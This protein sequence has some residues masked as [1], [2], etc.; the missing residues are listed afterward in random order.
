[1]AHKNQCQNCIITWIGKNQ[2]VFF[3]FQH[4]TTI[5]IKLYIPND[6]YSSEI[7]TSHTLAAIGIKWSLIFPTPNFFAPLSIIDSHSL[8]LLQTSPSKLHALQN[9]VAIWPFK[10]PNQPY[11][12]FLRQFSRNKMN[13]PIGFFLAFFQ[14]WRK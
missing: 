14:S 3:P 13:W 2:T 5:M 11:L 7:F 9:R 12:A 1:M 10:R 6:S 4:Y 8:F